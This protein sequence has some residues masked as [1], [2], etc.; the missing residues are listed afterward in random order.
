MSEQLLFPDA[1]VTEEERKERLRQWY[2]NSRKKNPERFREYDRKRYPKRRER[3]KAYMKARYAIKREEILRKTKEYSI[4]KHAVVLVTQ[5]KRRAARKHLPYD[6]NQYT[7]KI[8]ERLDR[9]QCELTGIP[10]H[11]MVVGDSHRRFNTP[12]ID[13]I[14]PQKGYVYSNIRIVAFAVNCMLGD[15]GEDVALSVAKRWIE[16]KREEN[17]DE[18]EY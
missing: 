16:K 15:W 17:A 6:L 8:Q 4:K 5:A 10:L 3:V 12:S 2:R 1:V 13:R 18:P 7:D 11:K 14:D 9:F